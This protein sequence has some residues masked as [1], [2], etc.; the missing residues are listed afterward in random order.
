M[1]RPKTKISCAERAS[2]P[3]FKNRSQ[4]RSET[5]KSCIVKDF[6]LV[7][8][9]S[10]ILYVSLFASSLAV[11]KLFVNVTFVKQRRKRKNSN[12][13]SKLH[14]EF[15]EIKKKLKEVAGIIDMAT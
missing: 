14:L 12:E 11:K 8:V 13:L 5:G 10:D 15:A 1:P 3:R 4:G 2:E 9:G 6:F 7:F